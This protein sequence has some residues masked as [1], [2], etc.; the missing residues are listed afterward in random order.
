MTSPYQL[1]SQGSPLSPLLYM[2]YNAELLEVQPKLS[3]HA[4]LALG[5][6]DDVVYGAQG[7]SAKYNLQNLMH[8]L[9][10]TEGWRKRHGAQFEWS[11]YILVHFTHNRQQMTD[12]SLKIDK[13]VIQPSKEARYLGVVFDQ[14]LRFKCHIQQAIRKG[15]SAL[16]RIANCHLG[17]PYQQICQLFQA[18]VAPRLDYAAVIW[19]RPKADRSMAGLAHSRSFAAIQHIAMRAALA[20][21]RTAPTAAMEMESGLQP[22]W[23]RLQHKALTSVARMQ[24]LSIHHPIHAYISKA[25]RMCTTCSPHT[26]I[27]EN[28]FSQFPMMM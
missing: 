20:C 16:N 7:R 19:N 9:N 18:V 4:G 17:A 12:A 1:A 11:K 2:Y 23:I 8:M 6:I 28:I 21:Y 22:P 26:T 13:I 14:E 3:P 27:L 24:S 15:T 5:F 25:L 10:G